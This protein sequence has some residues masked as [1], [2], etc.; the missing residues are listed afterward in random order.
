MA[1]V[2]TSSAAGYNAGKQK[3][4][5]ETT[6]QF[7]KTV[8][9]SPGQAVV[10]DFPTLSTPTGSNVSIANNVITLDA[11]VT[12]QISHRV[13]V[14][15]NINNDP[16]AGHVLLNTATGALLLP[17]S[18]MGQTNTIQYTPGATTNL[19][20]LAYMPDGTPPN[21]TTQPKTWQ[22][23]QQIQNAEISIVQV[24]GAT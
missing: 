12:Y 22:Y 9:A 7:G 10:V 17:V 14:V 8:F 24:G 23:P 20:L 5:T 11:N 16:A 1:A 4:Y 6:D 2:T 18:F 3:C 15:E 19:V 21:T 13:D